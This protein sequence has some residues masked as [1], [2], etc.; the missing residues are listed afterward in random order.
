MPAPLTADLRRDDDAT[1]DTIRRAFGAGTTRPFVIGDFLRAALLHVH[2]GVE[3]ASNGEP[4]EI[5]F[6]VR[7]EEGNRGRSQP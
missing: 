7:V 6:V 5:G 1:Q 4:R 3:H 2:A